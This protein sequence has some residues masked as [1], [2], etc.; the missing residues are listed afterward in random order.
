MQ[1]AIHLSV[2]DYEIIKAHQRTAWASGDFGRI[3]V[4]MQ[5]VAESLCEAVDMRSTD[6]VIDVAAGNGNASLAAAR[7]LAKVTSTDYVRHLLEQGLRR[8]EADGLDIV[9]RVADAENLPFANGEFDVALSTFGVMFTPNQE[10]AAAELLRVVKPGGRIGLANWTPGG[11]VGELNRVVARFVP[12]TAGL[13]SSVAWGTETRLV[14]LF[15]PYATDIRT[16]RKQ[17]VF[18]DLSP[19][20]WIQA[21]RSYHGPTRIAFA[22]LDA[23]AQ[24]ALHEALLE[25]L[26]K[27][28]R[29]DAD[30][31]IA[32]AEYLEAVIQRA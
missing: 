12:P 15:G 11:F 8:A 25:L 28:N 29:G 3:G 7:R 30:G 17:F 18:R 9:I 1:D 19:Q 22:T 31:L 27:F 23:P 26:A 24:E 16:E 10:R 4:R 13:P 2:L 6:N 21:F 32:P 14:E 5:I 20:H